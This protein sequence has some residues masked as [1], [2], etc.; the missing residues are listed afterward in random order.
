MNDG[1]T[2]DESLL[3]L[4][5]TG[6]EEAFG[7]LYERMAPRV[8]GLLRTMM[9]DTSEAQD[10]LQDVMWEVWRRASAF[11]AQIASAST[12]ILMIARARGIDRLRKLTRGAQGLMSGPAS[13]V[14]SSAV[15]ESVGAEHDWGGESPL[16]AALEGLSGEQRR[17]V[18]LA[19]ARGMTREQIAQIERIPVGTVKTRLRS[20]LIALRERLSE[21]SVS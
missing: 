11:D 13:D 16:G 20:A 15:A 18:Y 7:M 8:L 14:E 9:S 12:W 4:M 1:A 10:V 5:A 2:S 21:V 17:V 19:Y 6:D 3:K